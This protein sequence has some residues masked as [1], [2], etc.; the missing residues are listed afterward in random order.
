MGP[1]VRREV[2]DDLAMLERQVEPAGKDVLDIGC[3]GGALVRALARR[4]ARVVGI[5]IS[6]EQLAPAL[7][8]DDAADG[9]G[10]RYLVGRA[11][12]LPLEDASVDVAVFMRT[13][14]HVPGEALGEALCEARRVLRP[15]GVV[16]VAEPL[17]EGDYYALTS[18][19]EDEREVRR[20]AQRAL[21]DAAEAGL[22]RGTTVEYEVAVRLAGLEALRA[23]M[24]SVDATRGPIFDAR[25]SQIAK[26]FERLGAPARGA[27]ER[28]GERPGGLRGERPAEREFLVPMRADVLRAVAAQHK[29]ADQA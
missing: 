4:G 20:A 26:A 19:V 28:P 18:L 25:A 7:A 17:P 6:P 11:E 24:V 2:I 10:A 13:L 12:S 1:A 9:A 8:S 5:E 23:R 14:H 29:R 22:E 3:G 16:Y 21:E 15:G 27:G